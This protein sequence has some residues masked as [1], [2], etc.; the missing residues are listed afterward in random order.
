M[1]HKGRVSQV[2]KCMTS[3]LYIQEV[4]LFVENFN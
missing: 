3:M 4:N 2:F 1:F